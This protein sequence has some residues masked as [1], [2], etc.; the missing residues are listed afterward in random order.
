MN[1]QSYD[2]AM[3]FIL[4]QQAKHALNM[5]RV[6][7]KLEETNLAH[8]KAEARIKELEQAVVTGINLVNSLNQ[9]MKELAQAQQ[10]HEAEWAESRQRYE[11]E[12]LASQQ[13]MEAFNARQDEMNQRL[14]AFIY[15][16]ERYIS[17]EGNGKTRNGGQT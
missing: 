3:S 9:A 5:E 15:M 17:G 4:E 1:S 13:R 11:A 12:R 2:Q 7:A 8:A 10:R 6:S 16:L 14:A